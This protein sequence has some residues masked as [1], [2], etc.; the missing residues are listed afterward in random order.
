MQQLQEHPT[1]KLLGDQDRLANLVRWSASQ[2]RGTRLTK[3]LPFGFL[4]IANAN[5]DYPLVY[6][7]WN[8]VRFQRFLTENKLDSFHANF[9]G[10]TLS[11]RKKTTVLQLVVKGPCPI[12]WRHQ[13]EPVVDRFQLLGGL[14]IA[15]NGIYLLTEV[16]IKKEILPALPVA[17]VQQGNKAT[18]PQRLFTIR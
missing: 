11:Y 13:D 5:G 9:Y 18:N 2:P 8:Q 12:L 17:V 16:E 3:E 4:L 14:K 7:H 10:L 6:F 15:E 1:K